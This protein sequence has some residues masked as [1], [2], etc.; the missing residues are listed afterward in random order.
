MLIELDTEGLKCIITCRARLVRFVQVDCP[1]VITGIDA[2][3]TGVTFTQSP[4]VIEYANA[5]V[6]MSIALRI[7]RNMIFLIFDHPTLSINVIN[8]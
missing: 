2:T 7:A 3:C 5:E 6:E 1:A 4:G 8:R